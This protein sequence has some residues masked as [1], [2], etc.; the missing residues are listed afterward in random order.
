MV[1]GA[2]IT[3]TLTVAGHALLMDCERYA[4]DRCRTTLAMSCHVVLSC[5]SSDTHF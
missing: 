3:G 1:L 4:Q 5:Q 2:P